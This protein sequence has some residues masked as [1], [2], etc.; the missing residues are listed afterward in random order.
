VPAVKHL[1]RWTIPDLDDP[2]VVTEMLGLGAQLVVSCFYPRLITQPILDAVPGINVHPSDLPRWRGPDPCSWT[3]RSGDEGTALCVHWLSEGIDEGDV[4]ERRMVSISPRETAGYLAD[5]ME[6]QGAEMIADV[7]RLIIDGKTP[8][9]IPQAGKVTW[10]PLL[11]ADEWEIDWGQTAS[12]V[13]RFVR[14]A[15]PEPG[16]FTGIGNELLVVLSG[17]PTAAGV[18]ESLSPGTPFVQRDCVHIRC[19]EGAYRL[20][21]LRLGR[22]PMGGKSFARL[23]V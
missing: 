2:S 14:A 20:G 19:G 15:N 7:A 18:F 1:P 13:D 17:R 6:A 8:K 12:E 10:A 22:R 4:I 5:R 11:S 16:A 9:A 3:I 23:L 21:R